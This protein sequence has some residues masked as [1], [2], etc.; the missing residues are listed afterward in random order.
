[1]FFDCVSSDD[2]DEDK[3]DGGKNG[4]LN[5]TGQPNFGLYSNSGISS[6]TTPLLASPNT[7]NSPF[8][9]QA[10]HTIPG[11]G[12]LNNPGLV[13][14]GL[15]RNNSANSTLKSSFS[16][17]NANTSSN[18]RTGLK[19]RF[20][21]NVEKQI[22][23]QEHASDQSMLSNNVPGAP[24]IQ[25]MQDHYEHIPGGLPQGV[26]VLPQGV[27]TIPPGVVVPQGAVHLASPMTDS[28][29]QTKNVRIK[30]DTDV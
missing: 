12:I 4:K 29:T 17:N 9:G 13:T 26:A 2:D 11:H 28:A 23:N 7:P 8:S 24:G 21:P 1:M 6:L 22:Y 16:A 15:Q 5:E 14:N 10:F 18:S 27:N 30:T 19:L 3:T 25:T 20:S